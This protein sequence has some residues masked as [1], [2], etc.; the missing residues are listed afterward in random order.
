LNYICAETL[1]GDLQVVKNLSQTNA[2][3]VEVDE[4]VSTFISIEKLN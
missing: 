4:L 1:T 3:S 2:N